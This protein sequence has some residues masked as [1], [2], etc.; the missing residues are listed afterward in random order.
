MLFSVVLRAAHRAWPIWK[1]KRAFLALAALPVAALPRSLRAGLDTAPRAM[2][3][4]M[5]EHAS[6]SDSDVV[7]CW[8]AA[9]SCL[10]ARFSPVPS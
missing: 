2:R 7:S 6:Q 1:R 8:P 4:K 5:G 10:D 3:G 9:A